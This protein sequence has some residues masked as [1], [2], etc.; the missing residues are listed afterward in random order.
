MIMNESKRRH[1]GLL[2]SLAVLVVC[3]TFVLA[4]APSAKADTCGATTLNNLA[5]LTC[6]IGD[7]TFNFQAVTAEENNVSLT[8]SQIAQFVLTPDASNPLAPSFAITPVS[9]SFSLSPNGFFQAIVPFVVNTTSGNATL[10]GL[11]VSVFGNVTGGTPTPTGAGGGVVVDATNESFS[12]NLTDVV[13]E[14]CIQSGGGFSACGLNAS[15]ASTTGTFVPGP[16]N[17]ET[18]TAGIELFTDSTGTATFTSA[19]YSFDQVAPVPEP[20]TLLLMGSGLLPFVFR[21][22]KLNAR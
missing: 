15:S 22:R 14:V 3:S 4:L 10:T 9:G 5:G 8:A 6:T 11:D 7:K 12:N 18:G 2:R 1:A 13:P 16:I 19:T 21:R 17:G 20:A